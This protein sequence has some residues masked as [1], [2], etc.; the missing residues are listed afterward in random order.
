MKYVS[1]DI[2]TECAV[3][4]CEDNDCK[5]AL[6]RH[7]NRITVTGLYGEGIR[8]VYRDLSKL[9]KRLDELSDYTII[10]YNIISFDAKV[11]KH[12]GIDLYDRKLED[13]QHMA[14]AVTDR[15]PNRWLEQYELNRKELNKTLPQGQSHREAGLFSLKTQAPY[16]LNVR[17]FW[18]ATG[19]K[20]DDT[21]VLTD[22]KHAYNLYFRHK[23]VMELEGTWN[24]YRDKLMRWAMTIARGE[25]RGV[26]LDLE[27]VRIKEA[28][29]TRLAA[30][31]K[32]K[33]DLLWKDAYEAYENEQRQL[34]EL[35]YQEKANSAIARLKFPTIKDQAQASSRHAAKINATRDRYQNLFQTAAS[36]LEPFNIDSPTQL[37]WLLRDY[38]GYDITNFEGEESTGV[39]VLERLAAEGKEDAKTL[40]EYREYNKLVSSF[41]PS[42][43]NYQVNG[44]IHC[45]IRVTG[46]R[47]GRTS[48]DSPNLQQQPGFTRD[49]FV[50]RPGHSFVIRDYSGVEPLIV[51]YYTQDPLLCSW[52]VEGGN[53]HDQCTPMFF[54]EIDCD[55]KQIKKLFPTER[56]AAKEADLSL[57]YGAGWRR[58]MISAMKRAIR[59]NER[60]AK[61]RCQN[62]KEHYRQVFE[63]K[64]NILDPLL[65]SGG[66]VTNILGRKFKLEKD[67]VYMKG[68]NRLVQSSAS[69]MLLNSSSKIEQAF[70]DR[71][72]QGLP[73]LW[74]HDEL[75]V[76][77]KD[78]QLKEAE[79]LID[80]ILTSYKLPTPYGNLPLKVEGHTAKYWKK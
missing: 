6:D 70:A 59:W 11:L 1:L 37:T 35:S 21:Y 67:D 68:F 74:I 50:A 58:L 53:F 51:A 76:E 71:N 47:T 64:E 45:N 66:T 46:P 15:I 63:F 12:N 34:L 18:E 80:S 52:L 17:P 78:S 25:W 28:E 54:P 62:F 38:K 32:N 5:H 39:E 10:G 9:S 30:I 48:C 72:I 61:E 42:Y 20:D 19:N 36:K 43:H 24:F 44:V 26:S 56:D 33:L 75:I 60:E 13:V 27:K 31:A 7:R 73:L 4:G 16:F 49:C 69:D 65:E 57:I 23:K 55:P 29:S 40:L 3:E 2:E 22:C 8:E 79:I 41:F 77:V 14:S